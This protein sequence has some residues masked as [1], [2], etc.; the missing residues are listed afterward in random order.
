MSCT[1]SARQ[2]WSWIDRGAPELEPHLASCST[3]Q[4]LADE[5]RAG[6]ESLAE[7][8]PPSPPL[9]ERI[10]SYLVRGVLGE[11]GQGIVL[12]AEQMRPHRL[13]ALKLMRRRTGDRWRHAHVIRREVETLARLQHPSIAGV[14][15]AGEA[16]TGEPYFVM[17]LVRGEPLL[18]YVRRHKLDPRAKLGLF[19]QICEAIDYAHRQGVIHRDLKPA[20][21]LIVETETRGQA[22]VQPQPDES[23]IGNR[24]SAIP[25]I[26][27]FGLARVIDP[28]ATLT[29]GATVCGQLLGTLAYMSPEQARGDPRALDARSDI[30]SLGVILFE[31]L[32]GKPPYETSGKPL[33]EV[34]R[35]I[36]DELPRRFGAPDARLNAEARLIAL[37]ALAK[38]PAQRYASAGLL[39]ADVQ[40]YLNHEPVL[41]RPPSAAY[42]IRKW[43]TRNRLPVAVAA[44]AVLITSVATTIVTRSTRDEQPTRPLAIDATTTMSWDL[45]QQFAR[46]GRLDLAESILLHARETEVDQHGPF[47]PNVIETLRRLRDLYVAWGRTDKVEEYRL[48]LEQV[49][50]GSDPDDPSK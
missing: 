38:D 45:A 19:R 23:E 1:I 16:E 5:Y 49:G 27:D 6:I 32:S 26:L 11:G 22:S 21:I 20:N 39:A 42:R 3:C 25:K 14:Y 40:R 46:G 47:H 12:L 31:L 35:I 4:S 36:C 37:K 13:V 7:L 50:A 33:H 18:D 2:I 10:G 43:L 9:P 30:Y 34:V 24:K 44:I 48:L 17:E 15:E 28:D 29:T 41:A 8:H